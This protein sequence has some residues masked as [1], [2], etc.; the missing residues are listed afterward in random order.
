MEL[1]GKNTLEESQKTADE[2]ID[3]IKD[4]KPLIGIGKCGGLARGFIDKH[5]DLD[6][7]LFI[8]NTVKKNW[9]D[10][11]EEIEDKL[12]PEEAEIQE[13]RPKNT[14]KFL[15][16]DEQFDL[17][18]QFYE[19]LREDEWSQVK[20]FSFSL[21][22]IAYD[23]QGKIEELMDKNLVF[24]DSEKKNLGHKYS[25]NFLWFLQWDSWIWR[26]RGNLIAAHREITYSAEYLAKLI[27]LYNDEFIPHEKW[28]W[29]NLF[30]LEKKPSNLEE[31][32]KEALKLNEFT[33]E[34]LRRRA[35]ALK[36]I[37]SE[38]KEE[39]YQESLIPED[40]LEW[41]NEEW[42]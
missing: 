33:E 13:E 18:F 27:Y 25:L 30:N 37:W 35:R 11:K 29:H 1:K 4:F 3:R 41:N 38:L 23:P 36:N 21:M 6:I 16:K 17:T 22:D 9:K 31:R 32:F 26:D 14:Y 15:W 42:P 10:N 40:Y 28:I 8:P 2:Y 39:L 34:E 5:S 19:D 12:I 24:P 7:E 20:R